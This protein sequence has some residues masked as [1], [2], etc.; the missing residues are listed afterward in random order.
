MVLPPVLMLGVVPYT[1]CELVSAQEYIIIRSLVG[2]SRNMSEVPCDVT[3]G[4]TVIDVGASC[5]DDKARG[6]GCCNAGYQ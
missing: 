5:V 3:V 2:S 1:G 6:Y 4:I